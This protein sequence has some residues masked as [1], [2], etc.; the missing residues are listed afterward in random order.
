MKR[1][2]AL[3]SVCLATM[4]FAIDI[5][6]VNTALP[7]IQHAFDASYLDLR[8]VIDIFSIFVVS[9]LIPGGILGDHCREDRLLYISLAIFFI[10]CTI[11]G[12]AS[13]F[14]ALL[15]GRAIQGIALASLFP[16]TLAVMTHL[17]PAAEK[18]KAVSI[19]SMA[20]GMGLAIGPALGGFIISFASWRWVFLFNLPFII[21]SIALGW[22]SIAAD[23]KPKSQLRLRWHSITLF[24]AAI[25]ALITGVL[26]EPNYG[27]DSALIIGLLLCGIVLL[28]LF[29]RIE[30]NKA[31]P[32][33][34]FKL[35]KHPVFVQACCITFNCGFMLYTLLYLA[36]LYLHDI[37][38]HHGYE[39]GLLMAPISISLVI[40]SRLIPSFTRHLNLKNL[41]LIGLCLLIIGNLMQLH[42]SIQRMPIYICLTFIVIGFAWG[43][44]YAGSSSYSLTVIPDEKIHTASSV[45]MTIRNFGGG[46]GLAIAGTLFYH[47]RNHALHGPLTQ[48]T[49]S[50][51]LKQISFMHGYYA[52]V[53]LI[54]ALLIMALLILFYKP[55]P[56]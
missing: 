5:S 34:D 41:L 55:K 6:I 18:T 7:A 43:I 29:Y 24:A 26:E 10:G 37:L 4:L 28:Y 36:P 44:A 33:I 40:S 51:Q 25:A 56:Q 30:R 14:T 20:S 53:I 3:T 49:T 27:I 32:L 12:S 21:V 17:Y 45:F 35:F 42:F 11:A 16:T 52:C 38:A 31:D 9:L 13:S 22:L 48:F 1:T 15:I 2:F 46:L 39:L 8:W 19:W 50:H 54:T 47:I 23:T